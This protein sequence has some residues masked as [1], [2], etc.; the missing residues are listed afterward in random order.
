MLLKSAWSENNIDIIGNFI[1]ECSGPTLSVNI[2]DLEKQLFQ[3]P[4][5]SQCRRLLGTRNI[6]LPLP[7]FNLLIKILSFFAPDKDRKVLKTLP[8]FLEYLS[9]PQVFEDEKTE[10]IVRKTGIKKPEPD[11]YLDTIIQF[12]QNKS[13]N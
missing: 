7:V 3:Y 8:H 2:L 13:N 5:F 1:H 12:Y 9:D 6:H 10:E 4:H 11:L